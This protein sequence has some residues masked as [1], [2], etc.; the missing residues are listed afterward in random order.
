MTNFIIPKSCIHRELGYVLLDKKLKQSFRYVNKES[1]SFISSN[2]YKDKVGDYWPSAERV[3]P[4]DYGLE[5][6]SDLDLYKVDYINNVFYWPEMS[7]FD[8][9]LCAI[10]LLDICDYLLSNGFSLE[11]HLWNMI[12]N[13]G[14]PQLIDIGDFKAKPSLSHAVNTVLSILNPNSS[15]SHCPIRPTQWISNY[16]EIYE[17]VI[18]LKSFPQDT[19][20]KELYSIIN[21]IKVVQQDHY[22]DSYPMQNNIPPTLQEIQPYASEHRPELCSVIAEMTPS[23]LIDI[24]CSKGLYSF[25]AS[26]FGH[27]T[28]GI[29]YSHN[30]IHE[31]NQNAIKIK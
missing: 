23:S 9:K 17:S 1:S 7:F 14:S 22:W 2:L 16:K 8:I 29:D 15:E 28:T 20:I 26:S 10:K 25:Y 19:I 5:P 27:S 12:L 13:N 31:A 21:N 30:A 11:S 18:K 24:G 6:V 4:A 3:K